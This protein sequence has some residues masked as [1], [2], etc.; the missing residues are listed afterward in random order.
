MIFNQI[1]TY[2]DHFRVLS[3]TQLFPYLTLI[4]SRVDGPKCYTELIS[5]VR[6]PIA[7][8]CELPTTGREV[9]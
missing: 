2:H 1:S 6:L 7:D 8:N 3:K 9:P 5:L 4:S